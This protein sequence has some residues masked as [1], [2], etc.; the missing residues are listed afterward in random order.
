MHFKHQLTKSF[1]I[2]VVL[3]LYISIVGSH[4]TLNYIFLQVSLS[5]TTSER[6][7][8]MSEKGMYCRLCICIGFTNIFE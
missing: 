8:K 4:I 7:K 5:Y 6:H 3:E 1:V 2:G